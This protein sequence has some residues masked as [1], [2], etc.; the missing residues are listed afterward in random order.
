MERHFL[1]VG[2]EEFGETNGEVTGEGIGE[3]TGEEIG[4]E[5]LEADEYKELLEF[6]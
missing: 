6:E 2:G 1:G 3:V 4:D 5:V